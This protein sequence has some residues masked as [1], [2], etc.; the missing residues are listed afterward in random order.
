M[1]LGNLIQ[2]N[3]RGEQERLL[4][5]N[6][7]MTYF[8]KVYSSCSN[9]ARSYLNVP[10]SGTGAFGSKINIKLPHNGDLLS[11]IYISLELPLIDDQDIDSNT[12]KL[13]Y[14]NGIGY[15]IIKNIQLKFNGKIIEE[16][17]GEMISHI[18]NY[19]F[20]NYDKDTLDKIFY[21]SHK[22]NNFVNYT[23]PTRVDENAY[24]NLE[25]RGPISINI[26][27]PFFFTKT[28]DVNLPIC[29]MSNTEIEIIVEFEKL[30]NLIFNG[31]PAGS[32]NSFNKLSIISETINLDNREKKLFVTN[33]LDYLIEINTKI[34]EE[35]IDG[36]TTGT[37]TYDI[38]AKN[39]TTML[40]FSFL[41]TI[42]E[43][44][45]NYFNYSIVYLNDYK[46]I[47]STLPNSELGL[48]RDVYA[49]NLYKSN[50]NNL[51]NNIVIQV[52][53]NKLYENNAL[54]FPFLISNMPFTCNLNKVKY[55]LGIYNFNL[56][57]TKYLSGS[58]NFSRLIK[59]T[60]SF[61][62]GSDFK[63]YL[64]NI[65]TSSAFYSEFKSIKF[66]CYS[67]YFNNL[68]IKDG[69]AGLKYN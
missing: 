8:K 64:D 14:C 25:R 26:P 41:P 57:R 51:I 34:S 67:S 50:N 60:I 65:S 27:I 24:T 46:L 9:F 12:S 10:Y 4:Y 52:D 11:N 48:F 5:G 55:Q 68:I 13:Y 44:L 63:T 54:N 22:V 30:E 7:Q 20:N 23:D 2:I 19:Q 47:N 36:N 61:E 18:Y 40:Y 32:T 42:N 6:P 28:F 56:D 16:L 33:N 59:K 45:R 62:I 39:A 58:L 21:Y 66:N 17:N 38:N 43:E 31:I 15:K 3:A 53:N 37:L 49:P 29:A 35:L 1:V 69:L